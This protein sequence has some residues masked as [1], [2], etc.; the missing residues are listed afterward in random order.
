LQDADARDVTQLVL[1][2]LARRLATFRFDPAR[3]FH[4]WLRTLTQHARSDFLSDRH[5]P[6]LGVGGAAADH[7][8]ASLEARP[9]RE[10]R[11]VEAFDLE[12]LETATARVRARLEPSTWDAFRLTAL[13]GVATDEA[14]RRLHKNVAT[15]YVARSKVLRLLQE[16]V[17]RL[18]ADRG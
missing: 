13:E 14:A 17:R 5:R 18:C 8:L 15:V 9:D 12:L 1:V 6:G 4:G 3:S 7:A 16:E 11:L 2:R 10:Q